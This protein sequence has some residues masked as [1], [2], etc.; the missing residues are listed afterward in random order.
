[1]SIHDCGAPLSRRIVKVDRAWALELENTS[2][3]DT[4]SELHAVEVSFREDWQDG[5]STVRITFPNDV[6]A[7][8]P[9]ARVLLK[10]TTYLF[11]DYTNTWLPADAG[12]DR[13]ILLTEKAAGRPIQFDVA[14]VINDKNCYQELGVGQGSGL[15]LDR[16]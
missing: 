12:N 14:F 1:M 10:H 8:A 16:E 11:D 7:L 9:K 5:P 13:L 6:A 4:L 3:T 2:A 15:G